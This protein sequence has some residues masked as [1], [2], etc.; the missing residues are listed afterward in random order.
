[1]IVQLDTPGGLLESTK[2]IV[3]DLLGAPVPV[4]VYVA[5]SGAGATS[6]G[7][8][9]TMAAN[10]AAMAPGTNIG[11]AHPVSGQGEDIGGDMREKVENFT[12]SLSRTIAAAAR[13]QRRVGGEGGARE[14][15]DH[16]ARSA[17]SSTSSIWSPPTSTTCSPR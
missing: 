16:R 10:I 5:P 6:A 14:R 9:V 11:A 7:V 13:A 3:K 1:M 2:I 8:F 15:V 17:R 12:A 4:I